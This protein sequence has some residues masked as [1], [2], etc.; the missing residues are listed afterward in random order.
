MPRK[1]LVRGAS[2]QERA[3]A[4]ATVGG[5][6]QNAV[7]P[8]TFAKYSESVTSLL[9]WLKNNYI[10]DTTDWEEL[11][12]RIARYIE[13][14]WATGESRSLAGWTLSGTQLFLQ[15]RHKLKQC[16][17]LLRVWDVLEIR[18]EATPMPLI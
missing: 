6:N 5:L 8:S 4:R 12:D 1:K 11:D 17:H 13:N 18:A 14:L 9:D 15:K 7:L 16:W 2:K 3:A 10:Y